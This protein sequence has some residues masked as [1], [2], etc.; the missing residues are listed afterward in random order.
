MGM[1]FWIGRYVLA[2]LPLFGILALVEWL[3]G[4]TQ[5]ADYLSAAL[6]AALAA[7]IFTGAAYRRYKKSLDC[8]ACDDL[9]KARKP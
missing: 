7:A 4:S 8:A 9:G 2:G 3:K 1:T 5:M 6:W